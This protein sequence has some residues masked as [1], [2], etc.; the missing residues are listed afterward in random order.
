MRPYTTD[1]D[2]KAREVQADLVRK[3]PPDERAMKAIRMTTRL[4]RECKNA[5][6]RNNPEYT[7]RQVDLA[8]IELNYGPELAQAVRNHNRK[9]DCGS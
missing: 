2:R 6:R 9:S 8:F 3:I 1:T 7:D 4:I 5:I